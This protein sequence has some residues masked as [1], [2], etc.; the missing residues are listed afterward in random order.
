MTDF[1]RYTF[2]WLAI[3]IASIV[4]YG[5][6]CDWFFTQ[7]QFLDAHSNKRAWSLTKKNQK[8]DYVV[9][10]NSRAY[11]S[12]DITLLN[13]KLGKKGINLG[14]PGSGF[15]DNYLTLHL[16][17]QNQNKIKELYLQVD[18]YSLD[19][20]AFLSNA[21]HKYH[22]IQYWD[23]PVVQG[24]LADFSSVREVKVFTVFPEFRYV[25]FNKYF[26]FKEILR[27]YLNKDKRAS[28]F[29]ATNGGRLET[30]FI[31][32]LSAAKNFSGKDVAIDK[33]D[34][35]YLKKIFEL[36]RA[37]DISIVAFKAPEFVATKQSITNY[38]SIISEMNTILAHDN[39]PYIMP[40]ETLE[41]NPNYFIDGIHTS[42]ACV[43]PF[44]LFFVNAIQ[45]TFANKVKNGFTD[46]TSN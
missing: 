44:T 13:E 11:S 37:N 18:I 10:G 15:V 25:K 23:D 35:F 46:P 7:P 22:F 29:D 4:I 5:A 24:T 32:T 12:F 42:L 1:L 33:K 45:G 26:S 31:K 9:L 41:N 27:R 34:L 3:I 30:G 20:R 28:P 38:D 2:L 6:F 39:I 8:Y 21:F 16:F 19:S 40:D 14:A 36:C 17:L 43:N